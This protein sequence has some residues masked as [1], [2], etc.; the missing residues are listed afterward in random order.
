ML[1]C[2]LL[3]VEKYKVMLSCVPGPLKVLWDGGVNITGRFVN[4]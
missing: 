3:S 2:S 4:M 1:H